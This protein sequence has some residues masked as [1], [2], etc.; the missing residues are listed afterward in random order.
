MNNWNAFVGQTVTKAKE[1]VHS[2]VEEEFA[3]M[4]ADIFKHFHQ[5]H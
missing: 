1:M 2:W 3:Q 5:K 4:Q